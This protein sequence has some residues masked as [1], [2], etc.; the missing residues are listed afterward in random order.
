MYN[1]NRDNSRWDNRN[2]YSRNRNQGNN[3]RQGFGG[4]NNRKSFNNNRNSR[5][6]NN[7]SRIDISRYVYE[8]SKVIENTENN[9][10]KSNFSDF[11]LEQSLIRNIESKGYI[12]PTSI[13]TESLKHIIDAEDVVGLAQTGT[14][15][16]GAF[17]IPLINKVIRDRSQKVI[18]I[19]PT[20]EL[21][22]QINSELYSFTRGLNINSA[23]CIGG[24]DIRRQIYDIRK[25]IDFLIGTVGRIQDL[26]K[27]GIIRFENFNNVVLD[28]V[29][30]MLD[31]GFVD[32]IKFIVGRLPKKRQ[33]LFFSA[34]INKLAEDIIHTFL[35]NPITIS[36]GETKDPSK[37][38]NQ[39]IIKF[40]KNNNENKIEVLHELLTKEGFRKVLIF[41][42]TKRDTEFLS[43]T[44]NKRG[45]NVQYIHGDKS[46]SKREK[47]LALFKQN[48]INILVATDI[49]SRGLD[50]SDITHVI[51]YDLPENYQDYIHRIGRTGRGEKIGNAITFIPV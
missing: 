36:V 1:N 38:V 20:R 25:N 13:Q 12:H 35:D 2:S 47:A 21:A 17:L 44:L 30:T 15:K 26:S 9:T 11:N 4:Y 32:D 6:G 8:V 37:N 14:G 43:D 3:N 10:V 7:K 27:R 31:M 18:I 23:V 22:I 50:I 45:F 29:D 24:V 51:N 40:S 34:T 42:K 39:D 48:K 46:Q 41:S 28:E 49:A 19:V 33:S 16:T 5:Y